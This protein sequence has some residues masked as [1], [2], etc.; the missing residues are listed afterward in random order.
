MGQFGIGQGIK[1]VEDVRL[2]QGGGR[3]LDDV[4]V[5]GQAHA[6]ELPARFGREEV[7]VRRADVRPRGGTRA[8]PQHE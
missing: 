6:A 3:Y 2:L 1:R 7:A 4:N 5:P 8:A